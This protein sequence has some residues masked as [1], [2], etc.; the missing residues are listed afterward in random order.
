MRALLAFTALIAACSSETSS[1]RARFQHPDLEADT[2]DAIT[3]AQDEG[4]PAVAVRLHGCQKIR[5]EALGNVLTGLGASASMGLY[6]EAGLALG[7]PNYRARVPEVLSITTAGAAK[8][9]DIFVEAA[10]EIIASM[11]SLD[12]CR[13][14]GFP[15][16][17]FDDRGRCTSN[18]ISCLQGFLAS[19]DQ[20]ALCDRTIGQASSPEIG[21]TIAVATILAAAHTCE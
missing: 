16:S 7:A 2:T 20:Q 18:G 10:P 3:R 4:P 12:R 15:S 13:I 11:P 5:Y 19:A 21:R 17:M 1:H 6:Q 14:G 9:F 8:L